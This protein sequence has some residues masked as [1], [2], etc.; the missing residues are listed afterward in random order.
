[1]FELEKQ[2]I[3]L[4]D[5]RNLS[6]LVP[7][8]IDFIFT[9]PP[10]WNLKKYGGPNSIGESE[11]EQYLDDMNVVWNECY[12]VSKPTAVLVINANIRRHERKLYPIPFDIVA[13][14]KGWTLWDVNIWFVPNARTQCKTYMERLLDNKFEH[15]LVFT[16][17]NNQ[18]Y[19]FSKPRIAQKEYRI[20]KRFGKEYIEYDRRENKKNKNGRC[21]GNVIRIPAYRPPPIKQM[22]YHVAAFPEDLAAF[23]IQLYTKENDVVLDPFVGSGTVL[24]VCRTMNRNGVGYEINTNYEDLI[25]NRIMEKFTVPNW[26]ELNILT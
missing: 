15:I 14:M 6:D 22:N 26:E 24:K 12:R 2:K 25:R 20:R 1:M 16:K 17:D 13:R 21:V 8:S 4:Q 7:K 5:C 19:H 23:Y 9:S 10:Y 3:Y 18:D 11:Y